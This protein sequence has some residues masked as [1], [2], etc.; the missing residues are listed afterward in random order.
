MNIDDFNESSK[1]KSN[2]KIDLKEIHLDNNENNNFI[3]GLKFNPN[4]VNLLAKTHDCCM[5]IIDI[6]S[7]VV[8]RIENHFFPINTMTWN[9]NG[10]Y[11]ATGGNDG[12]SIVYDCESGKILRTFIQDELKS[13]VTCLDFNY[14]SNLLLIGVYNKQIIVNDLRMKKPSYRIL[15]HSEPITSLNFNDTSTQFISSSYDGFIRIWDLYNGLCL[16]TLSME[17]APAIGKAKFMPDEKTILV[18]SLNNEIS[19]FDILSEET[20]S[21]YKGHKNS[22]YL[23][24]FDIICQT[25]IE[26]KLSKLTKDYNFNEKSIQMYLSDQIVLVS[27]SEDGNLHFWDFYDMN[28][29]FYKN[30]SQ[31]NNKS[32]INNVTINKDSS[33]LACSIYYENFENNCDKGNCDLK[34]FSI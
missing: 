25:K 28:Y 24:E 6:K 18:S 17:Q 13:A 3:Q 16:K 4:N 20:I 10:S 21:K 12:L 26:E 33:L 1:N 15:A 2:I 7:K 11:I 5:E 31:I 30:I 22:E 9:E 29:H 27:G 19:L 23:I 8:E 14:C 32:I 34:I